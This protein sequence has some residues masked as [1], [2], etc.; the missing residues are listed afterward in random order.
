MVVFCHLQH[1]SS[2]ETEI[3]KVAPARPSNPPKSPTSPDTFRPTSTRVNPFNNQS[4]HPLDPTPNPPPPSY[5][6]HA[7]QSSE[8]LSEKQ[9]SQ[10]VSGDADS[11]NP[12]LNDEGAGDSGDAG[13]AVPSSTPEAKEEAVVCHTVTLCRGYDY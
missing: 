6:E 8:P 4:Y 2:N 11:G 10:P 7:S 12:F 9:A 1:D 3:C 13:E 5:H